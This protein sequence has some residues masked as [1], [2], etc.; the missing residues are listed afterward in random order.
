MVALGPVFVAC[1]SL[2]SIYTLTHIVVRLYLYIPATP[3][4]TIIISKITYLI[5]AD[6]QRS[7]SGYSFCFFC[8]FDCMSVFVN[9]FLCKLS[10]HPAHQHIAVH[11]FI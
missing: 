7:T 8:F 3:I 11:L 9:V 10:I 6:I 1:A 2:L 4:C 5:Y